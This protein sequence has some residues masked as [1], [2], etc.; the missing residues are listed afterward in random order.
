LY[1][2]AK[3][4]VFRSAD[5]R[6]AYFTVGVEKGEEGGNIICFL[7]HHGKYIFNGLPQRKG[8]YRKRL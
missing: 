5:V 1:Y 8:T 7:T 3:K 2:K 6:S 4:K